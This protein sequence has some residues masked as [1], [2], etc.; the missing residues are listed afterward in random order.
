LMTLPL[1]PF[2][3]VG[4]LVLVSNIPLAMRERGTE[5]VRATWRWLLLLW[6]LAVIVGNALLV[7]K[8]EAPRYVVVLPALAIVVAVGISYVATILER[9][10]IFLRQS[11]QF[12]ERSKRPAVGG[13]IF[14]IALL[15]IAAHIGWYFTAYADDFLRRFP[16][17]AV[18]DDVRL[19]AA[20][21][22][23]NTHIHI[24]SD[25]VIFDTDSYHALRFSGRHD[26]GVFI[27]TERPGEIGADYVERL[28]PGRTHAIFVAPDDAATLALL[29][30]DARLDGP[31]PSAINRPPDG[32]YVMFLTR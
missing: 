1:L 26:D 17:V 8:Q 19:R 32:R 11:K 3:V 2:F 21:L 20:D 12:A 30:D 16:D 25:I 28:L 27:T 24:I 13:S 15:L 10:L 31:F 22:P 18:M 6:L 5:G 14:A 23:D 29:R 7:D 4:L 9:I